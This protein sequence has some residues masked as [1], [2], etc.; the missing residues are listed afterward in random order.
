M[1]WSRS[2]FS[3][4]ISEIGYDSEAGEMIVTW[5]SGKVSA[6]A[7]VPEDVAD[8]CSRAP[9]VGQFVNSQIKPF[10]GHRYR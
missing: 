6:Y 9:S 2:V 7:D 10:Y 1:S 8:E 5:N 3:S 4:N